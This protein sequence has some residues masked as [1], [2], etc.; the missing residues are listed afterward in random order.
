VV[1]GSYGSGS[2]PD[3]TTIKY[4]SSGVQQWIARY[5]ERGYATSIALDDSG[6]VYASGSTATIKYNSPVQ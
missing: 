5:N 2:I 1:G 6:N 4:N 3:F